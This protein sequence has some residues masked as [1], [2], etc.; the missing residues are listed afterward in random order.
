MAFDSV[1]AIITAEADCQGTVGGRSFVQ[2]L[3]FNG[4]IRGR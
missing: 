2:R 3:V 4:V 1:A